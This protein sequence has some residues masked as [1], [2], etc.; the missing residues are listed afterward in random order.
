MKTKLY[1]LAMTLF[2]VIS[3]FGIN[4][5]SV[6]A[7]ETQSEIKTYGY[8]KYQYDQATDSIQ[9]LGY[10]GDEEVVRIPSQIEG[11]TVTKIDGFGDF[12]ETIFNIKAPTVNS[13]GS[14]G[15]WLRS[16]H[17]LYWLRKSRV[18]GWIK[19]NRRVCFYGL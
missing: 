7:Q 4:N 11:K 14:G 15:N 2:L 9:I 19:S 18:S 5:S 17:V 10:L 6:Q 16:I 12:H 3:L 8:Y 13:G 1:Q